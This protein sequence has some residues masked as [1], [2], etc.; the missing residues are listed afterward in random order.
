MILKMTNKDENFYAYMGKFFGSRLVERQTNDRIYD[1]D[2]KEW[3]LY[4]EEEKI[5][6]FVS[7]VKDVVKNVYTTK[8]EY[9]VELFS[10]ILKERQITRSIVTNCYVDV[11][12]KCDFVINQNQMY[13]NFVAIDRSEKGERKNG[14]N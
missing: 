7:V 13:K 8:E 3:Y 2:H 12:E 11:Y 10:E 14:R 1:D 5:K 4:F 6:G 9:L